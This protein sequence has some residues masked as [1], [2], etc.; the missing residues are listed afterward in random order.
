MATLTAYATTGDGYIS[1]NNASYATANS[2]SGLSADTA[3]TIAT[4]GQNVSGNYF[5]WQS[6][7]SFD[8]SAIPD[9]ATISAA[10]LDLYGQADSSTTDFALRWRIYD[11]SSGGLTTADWRTAAQLGGLT[12]L[13]EYNTSGG[14]TTSGYNAMPATSPTNI[15]KTGTT[16]VI[17]YSAE[18]Q[19]SSAPTNPEYV[20]F[21]TTDQT[22]TTQDPKL[23]VAYGW[24]V[25]GNFT[26]EGYDTDF[27]YGGTGFS[28]DASLT[29]RQSGDLL[30]AVF[31]SDYTSAL[32]WTPPSGW[33]L[34]VEYTTGHRTAVWTKISDG[35]EGTLSW[36]HNSNIG[37]FASI[38]CIRNPNGLQVDSGVISNGYN[39]AT[40]GST[41]CTSGAITTTRNNVALINWACWRGSGNAIVTVTP[42]ASYTEVFD[43]NLNAGAGSNNYGQ[44]LSV[45]FQ[46]AQG[47]SAN[48]SATLSSSSSNR[49]F[50]LALREP[51]NDP[52]TPT[53]DSPANAAVIYANQTNIF[54]FDATDPDAGDDMHEVALRFTLS[55]GGAPPTEHWWRDALMDGSGSWETSEFF[56]TTP[57]TPSFPVSNFQ[58]PINAGEWADLAENA[59]GTWAVAVKDSAGA[60]SSYSSERSITILPMPASKRKITIK[61]KSRHRA[62]RW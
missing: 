33:T 20:N 22:G 38:T 16:Y 5:I 26:V 17:V 36:S 39:S 46:A 49:G 21:R 60:I 57:T 48:P 3:G 56:I 58:W 24:T 55:V 52:G 31:N 37:F 41:S 8:T 19:S 44:E 30:V 42:P 59:V 11:W 50:H 32:T 28:V 7:F 25:G 43:E 9:A 12:A 35:T 4:A 61:S 53:L 18:D 14:W 2:G 6:F 51:N 40:A 27:G 29:G 62:S 54:Q 23:T 34:L 47:A 13:G 45:R 1:S 15:T 10:S